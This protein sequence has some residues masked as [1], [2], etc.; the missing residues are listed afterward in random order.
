MTVDCEGQVARLR[1]EWE[2]EIAAAAREDPD[3]VFPAYS[4]TEFERRVETGVQ[5]FGFRV[6][7]LEWLTPLQAAPAL[8]VQWDDPGVLDDLVRLHDDLM[9]M[10]RILDP[11]A[12][13]GSS[14][15]E[16]FYFEARDSDGVPFVAYASHSRGD[17]PSGAVLTRF[18][19]FLLRGP[20]EVMTGNQVILCT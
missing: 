18:H 8:V 11:E 15:F 19:E 9:A 17:E 20:P 5:K 12:P 16:A 3:R 7:E 14:T 4:R 6:V 10:Y 13:D 2:A 1:S